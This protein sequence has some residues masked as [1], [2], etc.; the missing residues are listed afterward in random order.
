MKQLQFEVLFHNAFGKTPTDAGY[1]VI[2]QDEQ[3]HAIKDGQ[4]VTLQTIGDNAVG[5]ALNGTQFM[6]FGL[7]S[8]R[9]PLAEQALVRLDSLVAQARADQGATQALRGVEETSQIDRRA[10]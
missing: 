5:W 6:R 8:R 10:G 2:Y 9:D 7:R 1:D 3:Y 4:S